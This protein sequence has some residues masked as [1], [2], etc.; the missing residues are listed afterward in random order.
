MGCSEQTLSI[1]L[2]GDCD[3]LITGSAGYDYAVSQCHITTCASLL[4][5]L[6]TALVFVLTAYT[7]ACPIDLSI[8][9]SG[10]Q[11]GRCRYKRNHTVLVLRPGSGGD[12]QIK[13]TMP[14]TLARSLW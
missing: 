10:C 8:C 2:L 9:M 12:Y 11:N 1:Q 4:T 3:T 13:L 7:N 14:L 6:F 5:S